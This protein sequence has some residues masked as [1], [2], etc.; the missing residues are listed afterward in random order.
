MYFS[1]WFMNQKNGDPS[2]SLFFWSNPPWVDPL[3]LQD[4]SETVSFDV[5]YWTWVP[6]GSGEVE[7]RKEGPVKHPL[8]FGPIYG[9]VYNP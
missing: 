4:T 3:E 2:F 8:I 1:V 7:G 5:N 9:G 6:R